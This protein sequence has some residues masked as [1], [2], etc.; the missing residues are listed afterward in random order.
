MSGWIKVKT[1][2]NKKTRIKD[3]GAVWLCRGGG[4]FLS[5]RQEKCFFQGIQREVEKTP[6]CALHLFKP[7]FGTMPGSKETGFRAKQWKQQAN[8]QWLR[9]AVSIIWAEH[10]GGFGAEPL[11]ARWLTQRRLLTGLPMARWWCFPSSLSSWQ[12]GGLA[13][14]L[15]TFPSKCLLLFFFFK[16]SCH[17]YPV[18]KKWGQGEEK[19]KDPFIIRIPCS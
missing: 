16:V 6:S 11:T 7:L 4:I 9:A 18:R 3:A 13:P 1:W 2:G 12:W 8:R 10:L 17:F 14:F 5:Q 15:P 19:K